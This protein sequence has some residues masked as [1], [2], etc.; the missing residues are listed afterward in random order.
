V[1]YNKAQ[2]QVPTVR[3]CFPPATMEIARNL[4]RYAT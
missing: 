1:K 2:H 3:D 4:N